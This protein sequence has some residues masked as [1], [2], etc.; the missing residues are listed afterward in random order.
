MIMTKYRI[1]LFSIISSEA[2][3]KALIKV[4][5]TNGII[6]GF[7]GNKRLRPN[8]S[9]FDILLISI[10]NPFIKTFHGICKFTGLNSTCA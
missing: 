9:C 10:G 3:N 1:T 4:V 7:N 6:L 2:V 8:M 5:S